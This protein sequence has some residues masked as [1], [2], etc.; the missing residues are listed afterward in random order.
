MRTDKY[1]LHV[2]LIASLA[3]RKTRLLLELINDDDVLVFFLNHEKYRA[4]WARCQRYAISTQTEGQ[5]V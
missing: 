5:T 2:I 1:P 4:F 3:I